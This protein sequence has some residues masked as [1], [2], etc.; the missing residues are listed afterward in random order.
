MRR[1]FLAGLIFSLV[2]LFQPQGTGQSGAAAPPAAPAPVAPAAAAPPAPV[3][4][5]ITP[6]PVAGTILTGKGQPRDGNYNPVEIFVCVTPKKPPVPIPD[7]STAGY[8]VVP[9]AAPSVAETQY[10]ETNADGD[11]TA[12][13]KVALTENS[14]VW[15]T[16]VALFKGTAAPSQSTDPIEIAAGEIRSPTSSIEHFGIAGV[17][18]S[19]ASSTSP[20]AK[21]FA[22]LYGDIPLKPSL[23]RGYSTR[24]RGWGYARLGSVSET[25][26]GVISSSGS[27]IATTASSTQ[28]Q[29]LV[30]SGEFG[31]GLEFRF[32]PRKLDPAQTGKTAFN[33]MP[34]LSVI[35]GGGGL[36]PLSTQQ[37]TTSS[38]PAYDVTPAVQQYYT[39]GSYGNQYLK[40]FETLC[41][42][43]DAP[44]GQ[45]DTGASCYVAFYPQDRARF[46]R[47]Y[48][49]GLRVKVPIRVQ[50]GSPTFFPATF[51]LTIGQ[52]DYVTGGELHNWVT[53]IG[54][55]APLYVAGLVVFGG[56]DMAVT[57]QSIAP[58]PLLLPAPTSGANVP[59]AANTINIITPP[60]NRDR[61]LLGIGFDIAGWIQKMQQSKTA[62]GSD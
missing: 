54:G 29:Q 20:E 28:V 24:F 14:Y 30:Q 33:G 25:N 62:T 60:P 12:K 4:P 31:A 32:S 15:V 38:Q 9:P 41:P 23:N 40:S 2:C 43:A 45:T 51:D 10:F 47:N 44:T 26:L 36:T 11:F 17:T 16:Q 39:T 56:M 58:E 13:L 55:A 5:S 1:L 22:E 37:Q 42:A 21:L 3:A 61:Y 46:F 35:V 7:C 27:S 6:S 18:I 52:N 8:L 53:H 49:A 57:G 48:G 59:T 34:S 50:S 19:A